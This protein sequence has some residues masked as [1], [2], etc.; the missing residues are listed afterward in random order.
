MEYILRETKE[1]SS[2]KTRFF[3]TSKHCV[4]VIARN[5]YVIDIYFLAAKKFK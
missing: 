1:C 4:S 3:S 2:F 5:A